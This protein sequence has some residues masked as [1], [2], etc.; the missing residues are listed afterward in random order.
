M[1]HLFMNWKTQNVIFNI[2]LPLR[3]QIFCKGFLQNNIYFI[4]NK[5]HFLDKR[6]SF[7]TGAG[8]S[9]SAGIPDFRSPNGGLFVQLK[10][11]YKLDRLEE[12]FCIDLFKRKPELYYDFANQSN[13]DKYEPTAAHVNSSFEIPI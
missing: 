10:E 3:N 13:L 4:F 2:Y 7:L 9:T 6:I 1:N 11:K 12:F 5:P 8:I